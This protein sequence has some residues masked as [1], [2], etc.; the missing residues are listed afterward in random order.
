MALSNRHEASGQCPSLAPALPVRVGRA[1]RGFPPEPC[2]A[3]SVSP[4]EETAGPTG[5]GK[6]GREGGGLIC[7]THN[8]AH[9]GMWATARRA[10]Y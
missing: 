5:N 9:V 8:Q 10:C 6:T 1:G 3:V 7:V 4:G 2:A